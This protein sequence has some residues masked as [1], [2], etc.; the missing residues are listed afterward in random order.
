[1]PEC[2]VLVLDCEGA[3]VDILTQMDIWSDVVI[4]ETHGIFDA[5]AKKI[6]EILVEKGYKVLS[7]DVAEK[8]G[9]DSAKRTVFTYWWQSLRLNSASASFGEHTQMVLISWMFFL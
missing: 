4:V 9:R 7:K 8:R 5:P 6:R 1:L 3:E 2:D